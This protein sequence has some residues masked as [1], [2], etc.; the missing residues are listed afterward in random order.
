MIG[1]SLVITRI[2]S[3]QSPPTWTDTIRAASIQV[4]SNVITTTL[5]TMWGSSWTKPAMPVL[6]LFH[7]AKSSASEIVLKS[8]RASGAGDKF[9]LDIEEKTPTKTQLEI[10]ASSLGDNLNSAIGDSLGL[11]TKPDLQSNIKRV[12]EDGN[13]LKRPI[14]V[15]AP[16]KHLI[17][18]G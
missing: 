2:L 14:L 1:Y 15:R 5:A 12:L 6:S 4:N 13:V 7:S 8:L 11:G 16:V 10:I 3:D 9:L 18:L 17:S